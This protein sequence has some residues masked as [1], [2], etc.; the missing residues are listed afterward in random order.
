M[1][2]PTKRDRLAVRQCYEAAGRAYP[3]PKTVARRLIMHGFVYDTGQRYTR[4]EWGKPVA[5]LITCTLT[6]AGVAY[7]ETLNVKLA[8]P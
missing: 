4:V 1:T 5:S 7:A 6:V 3:L 8:L 2:E